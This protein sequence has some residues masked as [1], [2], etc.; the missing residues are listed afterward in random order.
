MMKNRV[1]L[2]RKLSIIHSQTASYE[3]KDCMYNFIFDFFI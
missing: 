2:A 3:N 1:I